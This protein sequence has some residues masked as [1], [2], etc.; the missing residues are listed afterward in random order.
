MIS[1]T[2]SIVLRSIKYG[3]TSLIATQLTRLYG[4]QSYLVQG[5]RTASAKG[6]SSRAGLLQPAM[7]LDIVA[8]HRP[9]GNLQRLKEFSPA[10]LYTSVHEEVVKNSIALFSMELLLRLLP[11]AAPMP[12]LFDFSKEYLEQLDKRPLDGVANFPVFFALQCGRA[13]GY[14]IAGRRS[15]A[16]PYLSLPEGAF[17]PDPPLAGAGLSIDDTAAFDRLMHLRSFDALPGVEMNSARR[18]RLLEW[19]LEFLQ[20]HTEHMRSLKS[21]AVLQAILH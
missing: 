2:Q 10:Y 15:D 9:Q 4:V 17:V 19:Y 5:V 18:Q 16:T 14:E 13:L 6:R 12:E 11:E 3:E 21:L 1:A 7:I 20:R 8:Y